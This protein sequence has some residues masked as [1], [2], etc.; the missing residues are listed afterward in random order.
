[1]KEGKCPLL[2]ITTVAYCKAFPV[3]KI[4]VDKVSATKGL[5]GTVAFQECSLFKEINGA[6]RGTQTVRGFTLESGYYYHPRHSW[7][8]VAIGAEDE[9]RMGIDDFAAR[10]IGPID[11]VSVPAAGTALKENG[12]AFLLHSGPRTLR[13]VTPVDG[14]IRAVNAAA[15][16]EPASINRSPYHDGWVLSV[17]LKGEGVKGLFYGSVARKWLDNEVERLHRAFVADLGVTAADGGDMLP[18]LGGRLTDAQWGRIVNQF[19]G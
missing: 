15:V 13:M 12:V 11:R 10:L 18:E 4:P 16:S 19:F 9:A 5:C 17:Q 7:V 8:S 14:V 6:A 2:E 1:M 3:K